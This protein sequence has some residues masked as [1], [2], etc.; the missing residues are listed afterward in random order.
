MR[1]ICIVSFP[2]SQR[3]VEVSLAPTTSTY[4]KTHPTRELD[5]SIKRGGLGLLSIF[6]VLETLDR[7][8]RTSEEDRTESSDESH[9]VVDDM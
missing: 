8:S 4:S 3:H 2:S 7:S 6:D 9:E 1:G 5:G